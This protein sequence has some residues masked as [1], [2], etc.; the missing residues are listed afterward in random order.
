M[1][2]T[3]TQQF[4]ELKLNQ[5]PP[6]LP[7]PPIDV[8]IDMDQDEGFEDCDNVDDKLAYIYCSCD[9]DFGGYSY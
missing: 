9:F 6:P 7:P 3:I 1:D 8:D 2:A 4:S 5:P